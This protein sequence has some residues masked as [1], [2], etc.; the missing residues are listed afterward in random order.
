VR[1]R[2]Q[3][4]LPI[5]CAS[6]SRLAEVA[7]G[8]GACQPCR[9]FECILQEKILDGVSEACGGA[10][11]GGLVR[12]NQ[13]VARG[14]SLLHTTSRTRNVNCGTA[15]KVSRKSICIESG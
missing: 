5:L 2:A 14:A 3:T 10:R 8:F 13:R 4:H 7:H 15:S 6:P 12:N 11:N 9:V 1:D